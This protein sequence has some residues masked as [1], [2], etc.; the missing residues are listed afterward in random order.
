[1]TESDPRPYFEVFHPE[2]VAELLELV[3]AAVNDEYG[4][5]A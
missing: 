5:A 3:D 4:M 1:M 2:L